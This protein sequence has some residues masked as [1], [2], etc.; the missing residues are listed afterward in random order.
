MAASEAGSQPSNVAEATAQGPDDQQKTPATATV[1]Q[2]QAAENADVGNIA[3]VGSDGSENG[4]DDGDDTAL[5]GETAGHDQD[6]P[7]EVAK[8]L[9]LALAT[10]N[11][12]GTKLPCSL[13]NRF[14]AVIQMR[15]RATPEPQSAPSLAPATRVG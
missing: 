13:C 11:A 14:F 12:T 9:S 3:E 8:A 7:A 1:A 15:C 10:R 6:A 5:I 4:N 2:S